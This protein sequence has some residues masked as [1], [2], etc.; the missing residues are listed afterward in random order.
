MSILKSL[1]SIL[2][3]AL[4]ISA[5]AQT[6]GPANPHSLRGKHE[7]EVSIGLLSALSAGSEVS[8]G[9]VEM[10]SEVN[11]IIGSLGYSYWFAD[12]WAATVSLGIANA[13]VSTSASG[14][15]AAVE[16]AVVIPLL[17]GVKY[18][19]LG[20]AVGDALRPYLC[21]SLGP[22]FGFASDV[23]AGTTTGAESYSEAALGTRAG[24]GMDLSLSTRFA[25]GF[26]LGYR[27]VSDFGRRIGSEKNHSSPEFSL[28]LGIVLGR[29]QE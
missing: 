29:G 24:V 10:T 23:R 8:V 17:F 4:P 27:L 7:I 9:S 19:P 1:V 20:L 22:Y 18:K 28:S 14:W 12:E 25:L 13:D 15:N 3:V 16:S 6:T 26:T 21:A 2:A 11:G 5:T